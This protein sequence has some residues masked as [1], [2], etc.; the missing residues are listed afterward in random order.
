[1]VMSFRYVSRY[2]KSKKKPNLPLNPIAFSDSSALLLLNH[3]DILPPDSRSE[4]III[5]DSLLLSQF[6]YLPRLNLSLLLLLL[7]LRR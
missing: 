5:T 1:M 4:N 3:N 6:P 2:K 7:P